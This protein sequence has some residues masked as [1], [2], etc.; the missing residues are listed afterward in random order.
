MR[1]I[2]FPVIGAFGVLAVVANAQTDP[3]KGYTGA[4]GPAGTRPTPY[5]TGPLPRAD[6]GTPGLD[7]AAPDGST[8]QVKPVPCSTAARETDGSTT[9]VGIEEEAKRKNRE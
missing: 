8:V 4:Y 2:F 6:D 7:V 3:P 5:S 1:V 9:C